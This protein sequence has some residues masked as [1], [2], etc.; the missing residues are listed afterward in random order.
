MMPEHRVPPGVAPT[1]PN[2]YYK[3]FRLLGPISSWVFHIILQKNIG[4]DPFN[5]KSPDPGE[6]GFV[7]GKDSG[8]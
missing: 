7:L 4:C 1:P 6:G 2:F 3:F 5:L 8:C